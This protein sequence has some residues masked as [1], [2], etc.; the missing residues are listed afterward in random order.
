[1]THQTNSEAPTCSFCGKAREEVTKLI[2]GPTAQIC[3]ECIRVS[4]DIVNEGQLP[5]AGGGGVPTPPFAAFNDRARATL[6]EAQQ[7]ARELRNNYL[8]TEHLLLG[9]LAVAEGALSALFE[10][11]GLTIASV[12]NAVAEMIGTANGPV[13]PAAPF[14]PRALRSLELAYAKAHDLGHDQVDITHVVLGLLAEGNG[15]AA[16]LLQSAGV[17]ASEV[18]VIAA[19]D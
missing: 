7:A 17:T 10:S 15:V 3:D 13:A 6:V 19:S 9:L 8:G 11:H 2:A 14:T 1:M 12:R 18:E 5:G 16:K 4:Y